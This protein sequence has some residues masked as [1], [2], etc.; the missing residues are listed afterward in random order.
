MRR[1][2]VRAAFRVVRVLV[3]FAVLALSVGWLL[4]RRRAPTGPPA[5]SRRLS[6]VPPVS[7]PDN[8]LPAEPRAPQPLTSLG[9]PV[10][11][12]GAG[13][14]PAPAAEREPATE[15][16]AAA[17]PEP[18]TE[19]EPEPAAEPEPVTELAATA[20]P[21]PAAQPAPIAELAATAEPEPAAETA[22]ELAA[23]PVPEL[24][25]DDGTAGAAAGTVEVG[26]AGGKSLNGVAAATADDLREIRG[27]GPATESALHELGIHSYRQLAV[28][29]AAGRER[30]R[31]AVRDS[32]QR[33][34]REDWVGQA[35]D[36]HR[37]KYGENPLRP[38]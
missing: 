25:A 19:P 10:H 1:I 5:S 14:S 38:D 21:A 3:G 12:R 33:M 8:T 4:R 31:A 30:V 24:A 15:L 11:D 37:A 13:P 22:T 35:A 23:P 20:E 17:E 34:E 36:L 27:I 26:G 6:V 18:A 7:G 28:L 2:V 16:A 29:D 9:R 32:R